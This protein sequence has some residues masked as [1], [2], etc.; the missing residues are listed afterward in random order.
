MSILYCGLAVWLVV[1][2][3]DF[4]FHWRPEERLVI[5]EVP[6]SSLA[7]SVLQPGDIV[8]Q[9]DGTP[10]HRSAAVFSGLAKSA[11]TYTIQRG[12]QVCQRQLEMPINDN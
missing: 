10:V 3:A 6:D 7:A 9:I 11:Y 1:P 5:L 8:L 12:D 2:F 4:G